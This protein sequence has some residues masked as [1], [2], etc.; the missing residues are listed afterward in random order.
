MAYFCASAAN[1]ASHKPQTTSNIF[2][3]SGYFMVNRI[4]ERTSVSNF[5]ALPRK[6]AQQTMIVAILL[7]T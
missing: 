6:I 7:A 2:F 4:T 3:I 1:D 5:A